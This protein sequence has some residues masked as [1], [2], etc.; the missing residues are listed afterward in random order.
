[1]TTSMIAVSES[2]RNAQ[3]TDMVPLV[4]QW[5]TGVTVATLAPDR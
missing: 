3:S 1:M 4:I 5:S 2:T